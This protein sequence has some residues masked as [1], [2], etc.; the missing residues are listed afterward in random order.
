MKVKA[1]VF[2]MDGVLVNACEIHYE[3]LNAA[4][5]EVSNYAISRR[6]H[7]TVF[8]GLP[9]RVKLADLAVHNHIRLDDVD[10]IS[11]LK[12][13]LT[14]VKIKELISK[15]LS[16]IRLLSYLL[17]R[18]LKIG[19]YTNAVR[20]SAELMLT[21]C[22]I[23]HMIQVLVTNEDVKVCKPDPSGYKLAFKLLE[24]QPE[25]VLVVED[26]PKGIEAASRSG[27]TVI[28]VHDATEVNIFLLKGRLC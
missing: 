10:R 18:G 3:A 14:I 13:Q 12:Q 28:E 6:D 26:S 1:V 25:E 11:D 17:D 19:C 20:E 23:R 7:E 22:G 2:D 8:N 16:K 15:D 24:V 5:R 21:L 4:L 9:T 27:A